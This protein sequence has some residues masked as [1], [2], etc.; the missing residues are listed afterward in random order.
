MPFLVNLYFKEYF[1]YI[2]QIYTSCLAEASYYVESNGEA[3]IIDPIRE[4]EPYLKRAAERGAKIKYIFETHFHADFISGHLDL[5]K[6]T[7][8]PIV[9]G[10]TAQTNYSIISANDNQ[11]FN[12]GNISLKVLHTPGHTPESTC[13]LLLD[14]QQQPYCIFTGDTLFVGDVGRPDLLDGIMTKED[15]AGMLYESLNTKIKPLSDDIIVYPAHGAGSSCGKNI[16]KETFSTIGE[17]RKNNYALADVTK[18]KFIELLTTDLPAPPAY[19][20]E[21]ARINKMGYLSIDEV[22]IKGLHNLS[23]EGLKQHIANGGILIDTRDP[24]V[25]EKGFVP[26]SINIGLNGQYAIWAATLFN[27]NQSIALVTEPGAEKESVNRLA[28]VGF[29]NFVG[30]LEGGFE[31]WQSNQ[32]PIDQIASIEPEALSTF[33]ETHQILDV[34]R[35]GEYDNGHLIDAQLVPLEGFEANAKKLDPSSPYLIHCA[36]GYRSMI[37]ASWLKKIGHKN[38]VN[39]YGGYAK[40]KTVVAELVA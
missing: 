25:F 9:Y 30:V 1:M 27:L 31:T 7:G 34:R 24:D 28:R 18:E 6:A 39:I 15:L 26:Q 35:K 13:Y 12:I 21:D 36:G 11:V 2:E 5:S 29:E 14:S 8:A 22:R 40:I 10:P 19:F 4:T 37:A 16:G 38:V 23:V 32:E 3:I 20:F 17:Q 33:L